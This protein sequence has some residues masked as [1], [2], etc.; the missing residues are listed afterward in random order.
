MKPRLF[1][2]CAATCVVA[3]FL[4]CAPR[5]SADFI[6]L[7]YKG[8]A[9]GSV[10]VT[11][12]GTLLQS[13][14]IGAFTWTDTNL[15]PNPA[16]NSPIQT[17]CIELDQI[18]VPQFTP[19]TAT[20]A[21]TDPAAAPT[22]NDPGKADAIKALYGNYYDFAT[23]SVK[24]GQNAAFQLALWEL[25]YDFGNPVDLDGGNFISH[26][27]ST[28]NDDAEAMLNN[29]GGGLASYNS[30]G[31]EIV[32]L[33]APAGVDANGNPAKTQDNVQD[34][35]TIRPHAV[36]TPPSLMLAGF[37]VLALAGRAYRN[38]RPAAA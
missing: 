19:P 9:G 35:L 3:G 26:A 36:P 6:N 2:L 16:F 5:A 24:G 34:H 15:S 10:D 25:T 30:S 7:E 1:R 21:I 38:R 12:N 11:L 28:I 4:A 20:F 32:A 27:P 8:N 37:G 31:Y 13:R 22:I 14:L 17:F 18:V 23:D 33:V 29:L